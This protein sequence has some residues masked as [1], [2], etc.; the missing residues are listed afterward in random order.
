MMPSDRKHVSGAFSRRTFLK[1]ASLTL[2]GL[3]LARYGRLEGWAGAAPAAA[4]AALG[5]ADLPRGSAPAPVPLPHFP[6]RLHAFVWRNWQL[7]PARRMAEVVG[8]SA[9]RI[10]RLG[11]SMGLAGPPRITAEQQRRS[12]LTVIRRNWHLLPY[13]QL[14]QLLGWTAEEMA[15]SLREDDFLFIKL[16]S[17]KPA[18]ERLRYRPPEAAARARAREMAAVLRAEFSG[19]VGHSGQPLFAFVRQLSQPPRAAAAP[20]GASAFSPRFCYSYFALYGDPLLDPTLD[21]YP[22]GYLARLAAAGVEGV[23]LQAVL[24]RLAP[25]PWDARQS[26]HYEARLRNLRRLVERARRRGVGVYLYLNEPRS[27]PVSFFATRPGLKGVPAG[28]FA[29]LCTSVPEVRAWLASAVASICRAVP[30]LA[31][32]FTISGSENLTNCWSHGGGQGCPRCGQRSPAEVIAELNT[33]FYEG[34]RQAG[35]GQKLIVWDWGW[36]DGWVEKIIAQLPPEV[37]FMSVSEWGM[38]IKRGGVATA[39]GEY[40]ISTIGPGE[41]ARQRWQQA[42]AR[43]LRT[44]AKTQCGNTWELSAVPY[45]PALANVARHIANLRQQGVNGLMLGWTLGGYPSPNLEVAAELGSAPA[46]SPAAEPEHALARVAER[47]FGTALAAPMVRAWQDYSAAFSEFPFH[48]GLVYSA[49]MQVGPANPLWGEAT[50]Y[51]ATMVGFPYDDLDAWRAV[52]PPEVFIEQFEK[53]ADGFERAH[54][55]LAA[56]CQAC[57]RELTPAQAAAAGEELDVG[58]AAALHFRSTANQARFI[59][60]RRRLQAAGSTAEAQAAGV[61]LEELLR[62]EMRL[63]RRL[64]V[65]QTRD[66][67]IGFEASNQYYYV[68]VDLA[69]KVINCQD[70]LTRWLPAARRRHG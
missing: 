2:G 49:P 70:L 45:I 9:S 23:W 67:R 65:L 68:P 66:S 39:V 46:G 13:D 29:A 4:P 3:G 44:V 40:S 55:S 51:R 37:A 38:P 64:H 6:D 61:E 17:L 50:G 56:A 16:G 18:C 54:A 24:T 11:R 5:A 15:F 21:P 27:C 69:E 36:H 60:A 32:F 12:A 33:T 8:T 48:G 63:A 10:V 7:V 34:I 53:V 58:E 47:R 30:G 43:G 52:Y 1:S 59:L 25:F 62:A 26:Q 41:R 57:R 35:H 20:S 22:D 42:R 19:G 28:D 14:L 31:G